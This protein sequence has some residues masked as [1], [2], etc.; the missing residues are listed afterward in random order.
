MADEGIQARRCSAQVELGLSFLAAVAELVYFS[1][2]AH[3]IPTYTAMPN[4]RRDGA[5]PCRPHILS[6]F[7]RSDRGAAIGANAA[8]GSI[9]MCPIT[10]TI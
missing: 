8:T 3:A 9:R 2:Q 1:M 5:S 7:A 10:Y 6:G 4:S